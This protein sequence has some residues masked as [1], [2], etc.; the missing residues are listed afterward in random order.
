M[1]KRQILKGTYRLPRNRHDSHE[2]LYALPKQLHDRGIRFAIAGEGPGYP[3]GA[4]NVRNLAYHAGAA[5]A[6]GLSREDAVQS[7]TGTAAEILGLDDRVGTLT[8]GHDATL[9]VTDGDILESLTQVTHAFVQ[10]RAVDLNNRHRQL[11]DKY[12]QKPTA[13]EP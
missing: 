3:G 7:I 6:H 12:K 8:I 10:G 9:V 4:S 5:V 11:F 2:A 13:I 1:Y